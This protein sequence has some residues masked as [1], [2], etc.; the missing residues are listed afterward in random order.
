MTRYIDQLGVVLLDQQ[1]LVQAQSYEISAAARNGLIMWS[2]LLIGALAL[3]SSLLVYYARGIVNPLKE[4][5]SLA[6]AVAAGDLSLRLDKHS[7]DEVGELVEALNS[8]SDS[9]ISM[10]SF[11]RLVNPP[12]TT[13]VVT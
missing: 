10:M 4:G 1:A 6:Q 12:M 3:A 11:I 13:P 5:V 9:S 8:M 7:S 2:L